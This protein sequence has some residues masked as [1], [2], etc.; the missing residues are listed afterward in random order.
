MFSV[1]KRMLVIIYSFILILL[2]FFKCR[3]YEVFLS[4]ADEG[5]EFVTLPSCTLRGFLFPF[6][7]TVSYILPF[8][9]S[10]KIVRAT[11]IHI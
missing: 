9:S 11:G 2:I 5:K 1:A 10:N 6:P 4:N 8:S 7:D 3:I